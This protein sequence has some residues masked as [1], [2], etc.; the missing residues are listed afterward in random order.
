MKIKVNAEDLEVGQNN[1]MASDSITAYLKQVGRF[2]VLPYREIVCL[3]KRFRRTGDRRAREKLILHNLRFV[4]T[5]AKRYIGCGLDFMEL[6]QEGNIGLMKAVERF[7]P[8]YGYKL[9]TYARWWIRQ[10]IA[11][12]VSNHGKTIRLPVHVFERQRK[13]LHVAEVLTG[14]FGRQPTDIELS[15]EAEEQVDFIKRCFDPVFAVSMH[16]PMPNGTGTIGD[17]IVDENVAHP[18]E[19]AEH[20]MLAVC[21]EE[22]LLTLTKR[23]QAILR[24]RFGF[25]DGGRIF[26]LEEVGKLFKVSRE[27][28]RQIEAKALR[29]LRH[30]IR[31]KYLQTEFERT[32]FHERN[33]QT[34]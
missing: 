1:V 32:Q 16:T 31:F 2:N 34:R 19:G 13:V 25:L 20:E 27:R 28:I 22:V 6:I 11:R 18:S 15:L 21:I 24:H 7:D 30:P 33:A 29:K 26:T 4:F 14:R 3:S 9:T 17:T 5:V 12:A 8:S 23:E 10:C